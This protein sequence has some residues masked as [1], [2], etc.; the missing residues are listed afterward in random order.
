MSRVSQ[1]AISLLAF[2][3]VLSQASELIPTAQ[4]RT[5]ESQASISVPEGTVSDA[6]FDSAVGFGPF[7][8]NVTSTVQF[9]PNPNTA[10]TGAATQDSVIGSP[11]VS[12]SGSASA[13]AGFG[14]DVIVG[15]GES[16]F[17]LDFDVDVAGVF[18]LS[19]GLFSNSNGGFAQVIL[20]D[21]IDVLYEL[22]ATET[23]ET[24]DL[25]VLLA[26]GSYHLTAVASVEALNET[27]G[28][29]TY[30][31]VLAIPEP[32]TAALLLIGGLLA[33]RRR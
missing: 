3:T 29:A 22:T 6:D 4:F 32:A 25:P 7:L 8:S 14:E 11:S 13:T 24:F 31:V 12:A 10:A 23:T 19:G 1:I 26:P 30:N 15:F 17:S 5:I 27:T 2:G 21:N 9:G 18:D 33:A 20:S 16:V 28:A